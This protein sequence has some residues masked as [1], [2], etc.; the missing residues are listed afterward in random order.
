MLLM[1]SCQ[2]GIH[3]VYI[4]QFAF[5]LKFKI[6]NQAN[7]TQSNQLDKLDDVSCPFTCIS[8]PCK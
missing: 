1:L 5:H 3:I 4:M 6:R 8:F 2:Y 7:E